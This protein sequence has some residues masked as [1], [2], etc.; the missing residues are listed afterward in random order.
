MSAFSLAVYEYSSMAKSGL[1]LVSQIQE[2]VHIFKSVGKKSLY[3][4]EQF[5]TIAHLTSRRVVFL[6]EAINIKLNLVLQEGSEG[7]EKG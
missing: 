7:L 2:R 4:W 5:F 3:H 6:K 1:E